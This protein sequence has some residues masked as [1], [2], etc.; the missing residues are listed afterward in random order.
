ME[1]VILNGLII[2]NNLKLIYFNYSNKSIYFMDVFL[3]KDYNLRIVEL[4]KLNLNKDVKLLI[5]KKLENLYIIDD[6][7]KFIV[8]DKN[9]K[10]ELVKMLNM[11]TKD[12]DV[13]K[14]MYY[15]YKDLEN[16]Y[17]KE[18]LD[19]DLPVLIQLGIIFLMILFIMIISSFFYF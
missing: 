5:S 19:N 4:K 14:Q 1:K 9:I 18:I 2:F 16:N 11:N 17:Q 6:I 12:S 7:E 10:I 8:I 13:A 15:Y 3:N